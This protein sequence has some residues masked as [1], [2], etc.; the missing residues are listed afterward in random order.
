[1]RHQPQAGGSRDHLVAAAAAVALALAAATALT[2]ASR[3]V[4]ARRMPQIAAARY[5]QKTRG[6]VIQHA[7]LERPDMLAV[8]G[9]SEIERGSAFHPRDVFRDAP[10]G[11]SVM[12]VAGPGV[13]LNETAQSIAALG[14][15]LR[16]RRVVVSLSPEMPFQGPDVNVPRY[17]GN[18]SPLQLLS[19]LLSSDT[20]PVL[21]QRIARRALGY[22]TTLRRDHVLAAFAHAAAG[23]SWS[24]RAAYGVLWPVAHLRRLLLQTEDSA[25]VLAHYARDRSTPRAHKPPHAIDWQHLRAEADRLERNGSSANPWH[26]DNKWYQRNVKWVDEQRSAWTDARFR[27]GIDSSQ[28]WEDLDVTCQ[29]LTQLGAKPL[30]ISMPYNGPLWDYRGVPAATR[31]LYYAKVRSI[32]GRYDIPTFLLDD[33]E[34]DDYFWFDLWSHFNS[35]AWLL[36]DERID[37]FYHGALD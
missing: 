36:F 22:P 6:L 8:F 34:Y 26:V 17:A 15:R 18:F 14:S 2:I 31:A 35:R 21:R 24:S 4:V 3:I 27:A 19:A 10:T 5:T 16:G 28:F 29:L 23:T 33:H 30:L 1:M 9:S 12:T 13:V 7:A 25:L 20:T 32:A 11:F 37:A